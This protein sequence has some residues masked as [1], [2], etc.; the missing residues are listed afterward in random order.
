MNLHHQRDIA[1]LVSFIAVR[2]GRKS[3]RR[4]LPRLR[5]S[6]RSM[7]VA[8]AIAAV[9]SQQVFE[10]R[11]N[12]FLTLA[13]S[14]EYQIAPRPSSFDGRESIAESAWHEAMAE[15][16]RRA[17]KTPWV[18]LGPDPDFSTFKKFFSRRNPFGPRKII[19]LK[20]LGPD[21]ERVVARRIEQM[22]K[23]K[24]QRSNKS[25]IK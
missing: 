7:M 10:R 16:Y 21:Y 9:V 14:H 3:V 19:P 11:R 25:Q 2:L 20:S 12:R 5:L 23:I 1:E 4:S 13:Q 18:L 24:A 22:N 8:V 17:A 15:R 6:I